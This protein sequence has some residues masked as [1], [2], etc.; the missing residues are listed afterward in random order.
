MLGKRVSTHVVL[1]AQLGHS[2][3]VRLKDCIPLFLLLLG[4]SYDHDST[5]GLTVLTAQQRLDNCSIDKE[6]ALCHGCRL[7]SRIGERVSVLV[8][9]TPYLKITTSGVRCT[10][11]IYGTVPRLVYRPYVE[12]SAVWERVLSG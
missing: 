9:A 8:I 4:C 12:D 3:T 6:H 2:I 5:D 11:V 1:L 10:R 7:R